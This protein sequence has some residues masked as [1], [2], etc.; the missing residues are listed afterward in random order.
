M[1]Y[2]LNIPC[3]IRELIYI[4]KD[5][6]Y[7]SWAEDRSVIRRIWGAVLDIPNCSLYCLWVLIECILELISKSCFWVYLLF[8]NLIW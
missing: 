5:Q 2:K 8:M 7:Y 6:I 3:S 1:A 4:I